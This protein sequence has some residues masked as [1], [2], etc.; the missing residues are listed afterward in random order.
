MKSFIY[1]FISFSHAFSASAFYTHPA[2]Q[3]STK[4]EQSD[5][6]SACEK[7]I[8]STNGAVMFDGTFC[9]CTKSPGEISPFDASAFGQCKHIAQIE[10]DCKNVGEGVG[11]LLVNYRRNHGYRAQCLCVPTSQ[12]MYELG[13]YQNDKK[14]AAIEACRAAHKKILSRTTEEKDK[15]VHYYIDG[16][17]SDVTPLVDPSSQQSIAAFLDP[18]NEARTVKVVGKRPG[19]HGGEILVYRKKIDA[20]SWSNSHDP[21]GQQL[22]PR[23]SYLTAGPIAGPYL[24]F[25]KIDENTYTIPTPTEFNN[26]V[27][28][29]NLVEKIV[30]GRAIAALGQFGNSDYLRHF[31]NE[32]ALPVSDFLPSGDQTYTFHDM[33]LHQ[34]SNAAFPTLLFKRIQ[35]LTKRHRIANQLAIEGLP[36]SS[37]M[38]KEMRE[39]V[40]EGLVEN[41]DNVS[42]APLIVR[43][44]ALVGASN[45]EYFGIPVLARLLLKQRDWFSWPGRSIHPMWH[46]QIKLNATGTVN[47]M[48]ETDLAEIHDAI[49]SAPPGL[50]LTT[51]EQQVRFLFESHISK[52]ENRVLDLNEQCRSN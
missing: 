31:E 47:E 25:D 28:K 36:V 38:K 17:P 20:N 35:S 1:A 23:A 42:V 16:L 30:A 19:K 50:N 41:I 46:D 12:F 9:R 4:I 52:L 51:H 3:D 11:R 6:R 34:S 43:A 45:E 13:S 27:D 5:Y 18:A 21:I 7:G 22:D 26:G 40:E 2:E 49:R 37:E 48:Q 8:A 15:M 44:A 39:I 32:G 33:A 29:I 14:D 10:E 24:G